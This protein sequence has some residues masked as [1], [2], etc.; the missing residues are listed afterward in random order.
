MVIVNENM[1]LLVLTNE[2]VI[3]KSHY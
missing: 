1:N 2:D 3:V